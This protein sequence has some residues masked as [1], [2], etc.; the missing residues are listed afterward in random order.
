MANSKSNVP[1]AIGATLAT[2][3][4]SGGMIAAFLLT[5]WSGCDLTKLPLSLAWILPGLAY[6][7][8]YALFGYALRAQ[9][10]PSNWILTISWFFLC[11]LVG[12]L[13]YVIKDPVNLLNMITN[14]PIQGIAIS[15]SIYL[16]IYAHVKVIEQLY[17]ARKKEHQ[18]SKQN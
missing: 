2:I 15:L 3:L 4:V 11:L 14:A 13:A 7:I 5:C 17:A 12:S 9:N 10:R 8:C 18:L 6:L 1:L 16:S